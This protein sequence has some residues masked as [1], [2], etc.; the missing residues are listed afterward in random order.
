MKKTGNKIL[1]DTSII[2]EII[3][4]NKNVAD[5][6]GAYENIYI[7]T[8]ALGELYTGIYR[9][10][11]KTKQLNQIKDLI[12]LCE[13]LIIDEKTSDIYGNLQ[14]SLYKKGRPLPTNDIW[15]A[16]TAKQYDIPIATNDKHFLSI[17]QITVKMI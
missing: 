7:N 6:I 1:L 15:I 12:E 3:S 5:K 17:D 14:A 2:I 11:S 10:V 8:V 4:G 9:V 13:I 16:A